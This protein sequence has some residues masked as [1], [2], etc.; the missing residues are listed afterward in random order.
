M[1]IAA[2][3]TQDL[4]PELCQQFHQL[5]GW[6]LVYT[7]ARR[8]YGEVQAQLRDQAEACWHAEISDGTRLSGFLHLEP[9]ERDEMRT[10]FVEASSLA[11]TL[12]E[13]NANVAKWRAI[14]AA[15]GI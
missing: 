8:D 3:E 12:A 9:P 2:T 6:Q 15:R 5:T 13:H 1:A 11:E 7:P 14:R 4:I 10:S